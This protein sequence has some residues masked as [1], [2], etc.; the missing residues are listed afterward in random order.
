MIQEFFKSTL[1]SKFIKYL[2]SY[3]PLP[4]YSVIEHNQFMVE[5]SIY[6]YKDKVLKCTKSGIFNAN[7]EY[8]LD[9]QNL[10]VSDSLT[11][12]GES[13][14]YTYEYIVDGEIIKVKGDDKFLTILPYNKD[15]YSSPLVVTNN[16]VKIHNVILAEY[17]II[18]H[19]N[20][21]EFK[22]G[23]TK[24]FVSNTSYYDSITHKYLGDYLRLLRNQYEVDL[25]S[26]YNCYN[27]EMVENISIDTKTTDR[28]VV[29]EKPYK[30][31][32]ILLVPIKFNTPY[33]I[34]LDCNTPVYLK[35]VIYNNGL[36]SDIS[37]SNFVSNLIGDD[38]VSYGC[39]QFLRPFLYTISNDKPYIQQFETNLYIAIQVPYNLKSTLTVI[40]GDF[41]NT[42][43]RIVSDIKVLNEADPK[44]ITSALSSTPSLLSHNDTLQH[45][46]SDKLISYLLRNTIDEREYI[47]DNVANIEKKI[48]YNPLYQGMWDPQLR[49]IL[50]NR[51]MGVVDKYNLNTYDI[52]GFVDRD[53]EDAVRKGYIKFDST[54]I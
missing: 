8:E 52:L 29:V 12:K 40:E 16:I 44:R 22:N 20:F 51:Y 53:I 47:D 27:Y 19:Y 23:I 2:L 18:N 34:A 54:K 5:G 21:G 1:I 43:K 6:I 42:S 7:L 28:Q 39:T 46:F 30:G 14:N 41:T 25:M 24:R 4:L 49:Y 38:V 10:C 3:T 17:K 13:P 37:N 48:G 50:H 33:T 32:K 9:S 26:L 45:P 11:V 31:Y 35:G 15:E 36:V